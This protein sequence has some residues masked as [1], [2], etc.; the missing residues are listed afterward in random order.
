[1]GPIGIHIDMHSR[2]AAIPGD[3]D[4]RMMFSY[5]Y[6]IARFVEAALDLP[7]WEEEMYCYSDLSTYNKV[8]ELAEKN[9]GEKY[10]CGTLGM[11]MLILSRG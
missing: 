6:D 10:E 7:K 1:M 9:T 8:V 5:S 3:G 4:T 11:C 2:T